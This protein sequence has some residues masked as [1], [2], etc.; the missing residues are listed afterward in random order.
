M[1]KQQTDAATYLSVSIGSCAERT[2]RISHVT[3]KTKYC[4][5]T[6]TRVGDIVKSTLVGSGRGTR[7]G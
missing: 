5:L 6:L 4:R 2:R 7:R 3:A 1:R